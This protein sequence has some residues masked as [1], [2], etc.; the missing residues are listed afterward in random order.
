[1]IHLTYILYVCIVLLFTGCASTKN[2]TSNTTLQSTNTTDAPTQNEQTPNTAQTTT[3]DSPLRIACVGDSLTEGY[4]YANAKNESYPV[5]LKNIIDKSNVEVKNFG[6]SNKTAMHTELNQ[7]KTLDPY[8]ETD[9]YKDSLVFNPDIVVIMFGTNDIK[10]QN[11]DKKEN[12]IKD[13]TALIKSYQALSS[14]P[15]IYI[16][17]PTP[18]FT[19]LLGITDARIKNE[20]IPK[21]KTIASANNLKLID[22]HTPFKDKSHLFHD[23]L[24][25]NKQG[26]IDIANIVYEN[27]Y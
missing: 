2:S 26:A 22:L 4:G 7:A 20:L 14:N 3:N 13:Y 12:F 18:S 9:E 16:C 25:P 27:I 6:K 23:S 21:I 10:N 19:N 17:F 1:M 15:V 11:W 24:H 8:K 5:Q